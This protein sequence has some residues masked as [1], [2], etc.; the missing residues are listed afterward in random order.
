[1]L[2]HYNIIIF[3]KIF[4]LKTFRKTVWYIIYTQCIKKMHKKDSHCLHQPAPI[5]PQLTKFNHLSLNSKQ[6]AWLAFFIDKVSKTLTNFVWTSLSCNVKFFFQGKT[7]QTDK[8]G[9][10][11]QCCSLSSILE[12]SFISSLSTR[13][14][15]S[16]FMQIKPKKSSTSFWEIFYPTVFDNEPAWMLT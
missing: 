7:Q 4:T 3:V 1:M 9:H 11:F 13:T 16:I 6:N 5:P 8:T 15:A 12:G 2:L 14:A 10:I